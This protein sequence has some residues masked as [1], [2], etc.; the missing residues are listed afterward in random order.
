MNELE[1]KIPDGSDADDLSSQVAEL[2]RAVVALL[3]ALFVVSGT[4][5]VFLGVQSRRF[6][7]ELDATRPQAAKA[8]DFI[9]KE[10]PVIRSFAARLADYG[11]TH[12]DIRP[13]IARYG[14]GLTNSGLNAAPAAAT[15]SGKK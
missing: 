9:A 6:G 13:L 12:S 3:V 4:I 14:I 5:S 15:N 1:S 8:V 11:R 7:K 2:R 10:Q